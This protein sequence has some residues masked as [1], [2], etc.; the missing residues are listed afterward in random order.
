ME[1]G[2]VKI[3]LKEYTEESKNCKN[4]SEIETES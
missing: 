4:E 2:I 3:W 1:I